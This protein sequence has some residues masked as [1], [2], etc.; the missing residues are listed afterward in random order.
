MPNIDYEAIAAAYTQQLPQ[1]QRVRDI[2]LKPK[3]Y[4][5]DVLFGGQT[6]MSTAELSTVE[7]RKGQT[8]V[9]DD[10]I[11][12]SD[13]VIGPARDAH[14]V[15]VI[16]YAYL[17]S[18]LPVNHRDAETLLFNE[19]PLHPYSDRQ[20]MA[21]ALAEKRDKLL[22][23]YAMT[24]EKMCVDALF[25]GI[26][27]TKNGGKQVFPLAKDMLEFKVASAWNATTTKRKDVN[28][29]LTKAAMLI[30][31]RTGLVPTK[32]LVAFEDS[33]LP[34]YTSDA[35]YVGTTIEKDRVLANEKLQQEQGIRHVGTVQ[36]EFGPLEIVAY[37]GKVQ[38]ATGVVSCIPKGK[39]VLVTPEP[40]GYMAYGPVLVPGPN[41]QEL[42]AGHNLTTVYS[43]IKDGYKQDMG[44]V[45]QSAPMPV[46]DNLDSYV[47]INGIDG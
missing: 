4:I 2:K 40:V 27:D 24:E 6:A 21:L 1:I 10:A 34:F 45:V 9:S 18:K 31:E 38:T 47:V 33:M 43:A 16:R 5:R 35:T 46:L 20:R 7:F 12:Y 3:T 32:L 14:D 25:T 22:D 37:L 23:S 44:V 26:V 29:D 36:T 19:D 30:Y 13:S 39:A 8:M 42:A 11:L 28:A 17:N 41:G 15:K